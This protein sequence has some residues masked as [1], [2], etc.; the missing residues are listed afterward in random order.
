MTPSEMEQEITNLNTRTTAV[1]QILPTLA[2]KQDLRD[3]VA[4]LTTKMDSLATKE[5]LRLAEVDLQ[6]DMARLATKDDLR[7]TTAALQHEIQAGVQE[8]RSHADRLNEVTLEQ[9]RLVAR[10]MAA[11]G[12]LQELRRELRRD[13]R[14]L[15]KQIAAQR[16][17]GRKKG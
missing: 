11:N 13:I 3:E 12:D 16:S 10:Q 4:K 6:Q 2:T 15:S 14:A 8:A 9:I 7:L 17:P 5:Q 1:D